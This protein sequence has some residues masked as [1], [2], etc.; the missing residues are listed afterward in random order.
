MWTN[1]LFCEKKNGKEYF[2]NDD[3]WHARM[4]VIGEVR[5]V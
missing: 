3:D 2:P 5:V 4:I 1:M